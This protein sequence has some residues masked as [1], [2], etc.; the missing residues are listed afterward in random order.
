MF[1]VSEITIL[2]FYGCNLNVEPKNYILRN[3]EIKTPRRGY[4]GRDYY[5]SFRIS[6][7]FDGRSTLFNLKGFPQGFPK[8]QGWIQDPI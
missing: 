4:P 6:E 1:S 7:H 2:T 8:L 5:E 3:L